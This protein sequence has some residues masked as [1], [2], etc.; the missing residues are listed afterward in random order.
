MDD[1]H[2]ADRTAP[3]AT[4]LE[5]LYAAFLTDP[6]SVSPAWAACF[7]QLGG[8]A[9]DLPGA[10][11]DAEVLRDKQVLVLRLINAFRFLGLR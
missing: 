6:E 10:R 8:G 9:P 3:H 7:R 11:T 4:A 5:S 2:A 1:E